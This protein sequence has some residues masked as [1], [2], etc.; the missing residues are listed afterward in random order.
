LNFTRAITVLGRQKGLKETL[1][2][3][4][5]QSATVK[6]IVD[7]E[8]DVQGFKSQDHYQVKV[9]MQHGDV[10]FTGKWQPLSSELDDN[11][12]LLDKEIASRKVVE[13]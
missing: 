1:S 13:L 12:L 3:G 7:R 9:N 5:V 10:P 8:N 11:K 6:I 2:A 4:R